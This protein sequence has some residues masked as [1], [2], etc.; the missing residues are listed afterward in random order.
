MRIRLPVIAA[1]LFVSVSPALG[2]ALVVS[3]AMKADTILEIFV[4]EGAVRTELE[5]GVSDFPAFRDLL[6]DPLWAKLG[7]EPEP[8]AKR[9]VRRPQR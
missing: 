2:D 5:I 7:H 6:P 4:E 9:L 1:L 8:W 3:R